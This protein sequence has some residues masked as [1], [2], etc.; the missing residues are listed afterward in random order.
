MLGKLMKYEF[1]ATGRIFLPVYAALIVFSVV[2]RLLRHSN[3]DIFGVF[4]IFGI[5]STVV[6]VIIMI[7][8]FV[9][10]LVLTIQR[11]RQ[12]LM[13]NE[14]YL[15]MT[16]PL[17]TDSLI[18][19]KLIVTAVWAVACFIVVVLA[20][21]IL[22]ATRQAL[23]FVV[24][25][26]WHFAE[27]FVSDPFRV[28]LVTFE[29]IAIITLTILS[30]ALLLYAC[31]SLG[32]LVNRNRLL[33]SFGAYIAIT[34]ALQVAAGVILSTFSALGIGEYINRF[35]DDYDA[36][37]ISQFFVVIIIIVQIVICAIYYA[38]TRYMLK[39]RLNLQ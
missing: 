27:A 30:Q 1:R 34:T 29:I 3:F 18:L 4:D 15:M 26:I 36:F 2:S 12:N 8:I 31:L 35:F 11:F 10:M 32:M 9:V 17:R 22:V 38:I 20:I 5:L 13:S 19:S 25:F 23:E 6:S 21:F 7:G 39:N 14:G 37:G 24:D 28:A 33:L 16:L